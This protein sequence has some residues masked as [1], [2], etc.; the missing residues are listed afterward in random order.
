MAGVLPESQYR[1]AAYEIQE[2]TVG[3]CDGWGEEH[4]VFAVDLS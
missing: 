3:H 2:G 1:V 4:S